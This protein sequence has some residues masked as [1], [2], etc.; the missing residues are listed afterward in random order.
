MKKRN[1]TGLGE[2]ARPRA[3]GAPSAFK[4][5]LVPLVEELEWNHLYELQYLADS[6]DLHN[7]TQE[8]WRG[9]GK[10]GGGKRV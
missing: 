6:T 2:Q 4:M 8:I 10:G 5:L 1:V 7:Q 3:K 9:E